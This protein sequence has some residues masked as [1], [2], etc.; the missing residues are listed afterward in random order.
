MAD[1]TTEKQ[2]VLDGLFGSA[3]KVFGNVGDLGKS[4]SDSVPS[5]MS[6]LQ[7]MGITQSPADKEAENQLKLQRLKT[8]ASSNQAKILMAGM[9]GILVL[10]LVLKKRK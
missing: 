6:A 7:G 4:F 1:T 2:G 8:A 3:K 10:V 9:A 5:F